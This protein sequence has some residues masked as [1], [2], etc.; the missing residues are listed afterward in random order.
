ML[1]QL[2]DCKVCKFQLM[3]SL[4]HVVNSQLQL[5]K[6]TCIQSANKH[7]LQLFASGR[8]PRQNPVQEPWLKLNVGVSLKKKVH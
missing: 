6:Q 3:P 2:P 4:D 8:G 5:C 7:M 1:Q